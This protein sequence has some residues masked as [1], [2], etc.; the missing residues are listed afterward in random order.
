M[1]LLARL[2]MCAHF[3]GNEH[4]RS[5]ENSRVA[6]SVPLITDNSRKR[7]ARETEKKRVESNDGIVGKGA[8][9]CGYREGKSGRRVDSG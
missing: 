8:E 7:G 2:G 9:K 3:I 6:T 4:P 5:D 1:T